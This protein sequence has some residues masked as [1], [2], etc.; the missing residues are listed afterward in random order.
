ME[1]RAR[2][3]AA[4][5]ASGLK[6]ADAAAA[7][8]IDMLE[9]AEEAAKPGFIRLVQEFLPSDGAV[10]QAFMAEAARS[11]EVL[12]EL[13]DDCTDPKVRLAAVK[14]FLTQAGFTPVRKVATISITVS[15]DK[16]KLL[17]DTAA[18]MLEQTNE[19]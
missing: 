11:L 14:E 7:A 15:A 3:L 8:K 9:A 12:R 13:R 16:A 10:R 19:S 18:E 5:V 17:R 1:D 6:L 4:G 2:A